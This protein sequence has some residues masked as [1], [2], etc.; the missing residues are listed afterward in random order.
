VRPRRNT[1]FRAVWQNVPSAGQIIHVKP[2][3]R[4]KQVGRSLFTV[5]VTADTSL[6]HRF[7]V[8]PRADHQAAGAALMYRA[9]WSRALRV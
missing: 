9:A 6:V 3:V 1:V 2:L 5:G 4:L 7:V 8:H